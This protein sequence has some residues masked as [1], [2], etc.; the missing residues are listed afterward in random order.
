MAFSVNVFQNHMRIKANRYNP[1]VLYYGYDYAVMEFESERQAA[2]ALCDF[3]AHAS[4][5]GYEI[6]GHETFLVCVNQG[7]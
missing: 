4:N 6:D 2:E 5:Y 1:I 7:D 3:Q